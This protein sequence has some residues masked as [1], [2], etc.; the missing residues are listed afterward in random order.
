MDRF[1]EVTAPNAVYTTQDVKHI[2]D[3]A[4][5]LGVRVVPEFDV[6]AHAASWGEGYPGLIVPCP[7]VVA[8]DERLVEHGVDKVA[9][10][11]LQE[12]TYTFLKTFFDEVFALFPDQ[13]IHFGGDEVNADCWL[14]SPDI[15]K[16]KTS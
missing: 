12:G 11:P 8:A 7:A 9:L 6:P 16:W 5:S 1:L 15:Q 3:L 4:A 13:Y 10:N 2:V 14:T